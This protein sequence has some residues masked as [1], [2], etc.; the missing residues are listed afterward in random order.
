MG[1]KELKMKFVKTFSD[2]PLNQPLL[3]IDSRGHLALAVNQS[4][5]SDVYGIKPPAALGIRRAGK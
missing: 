5:F 4:S 2:V 1:D 3:Y